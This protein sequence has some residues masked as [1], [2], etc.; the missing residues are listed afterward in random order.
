[1]VRFPRWT[2]P[3]LLAAGTVMFAGLCLE[4]LQLSR[5]QKRIAQQVL[6]DHARAA[7]W[8]FATAYVSQINLSLSP[9]FG[10]LTRAPLPP[11]ALEQ[12]ARS[13]REVLPCQD[14]VADRA[15][16]HFRRDLPDGK[17]VL[18]TGA[19]PDSV[20]QFYVDSLSQMMV[21]MNDDGFL[22]KGFRRA[23]GETR[24]LVT[25]RVRDRQGRLVG[26]LGFE[27]CRSGLDR[28]FG[29]VFNQADLLPPFLTGGNSNSKMLSIV[30]FRPGSGDTI[31]AS[32]P[33]YSSHEASQASLGILGLRYQAALNPVRTDLLLA[34]LPPSRMPQVAALLL[35]T[36]GLLAATFGLMIRERRLVRIRTD[37]LA[38][39]SHELRTP[40]SQ[41]LLFVE[42]LERGK[43]RTQQER[44]LA[45]GVIGHE[46]RRLLHL[47]QNVLYLTQTERAR[48]PI[49]TSGRLLAP[50]VR[51]VVS[52]YAP[53][54][55]DRDV[56][57][58]VQI[59][60]ALAVRANQDAIR[61]VLINLLDNAVK[62]GPVGQEITV[63]A[64]RENGVVHLAVEDQGEGVAP[65][66][67]AH[68]WR[69]FYRAEAR[70]NDAPG[71][72]IGLA[73]VADLTARQ[74]GRVRYEPAQPRGA[75]FIITL[76]AA[77]SE[78]Q[79]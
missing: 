63:R 37:F 15:R 12:L 73:I 19:R 65:R 66:H 35:V 49:A 68:I 57:F 61:Q 3:L 30:V 27:T 79:L 77:D 2:L 17:L 21:A 39:V 10:G 64:T 25:H 48:G 75:R 1:M 9:A 41:V 28:L 50:L 40:L 11:A 69:P 78:N 70:T 74:G 13:A 23:K 55:A 60:E 20:L 53:L 76:P 45:L 51:D 7:A 59:D 4:L 67:R 16:I 56:A 43:A 44:D 8:R 62:F 33:H 42:T 54:A 5:S 52:G 71:S 14:S 18:D 29:A 24:L 34:N 22:V 26:M 36:A 31:Y 6:E 47:V 38:S 46:A 72:G 32:T 58:R